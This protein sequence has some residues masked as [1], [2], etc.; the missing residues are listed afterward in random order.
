MLSRLLSATILASMYASAAIRA[1]SSPAS[2][3]VSAVAAIPVGPLIGN[4]GSGAGATASLRYALPAIPFLAIGAE[5]GGLAKSA[6][7]NPPTGDIPTIV[8]NGSSALVA[9]IGPRLSLPVGEGR[10]YLTGTAGIARL[11][12]SS[13][14]DPTPASRTQ[15]DVS[16]SN[17]TT[18]AT[19]FAW[20]GGGGV[21]MPL[22]G[23]RSRAA[24]D[25]GARY[26]DL[27]NTT[28][29]RR[30]TPYT[31]QLISGAE[32][33][34]PETVPVSSRAR[35]TMVAPSAGIVLRF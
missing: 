34:F 33:V 5:I 22:P 25:L 8:T 10:V 23:T 2:A 30:Y 12:A 13:Y 4:R 29:A 6:H 26:Y 9:G 35:A 28:Y 31:T 20:S 21:V 7:T 18:V 3:S 14:L 15:Y 16:A 19:N 24:V 27:G 11:W 17:M 32:G 1:Q